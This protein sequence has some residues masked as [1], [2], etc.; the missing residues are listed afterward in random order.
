LQA[1]GQIYN[2]HGS[3]LRVQ[4]IVLL[5]EVL[6]EIATHAHKINNDVELRLKLQRLP[7]AAQMPDPP[8]LRLETDSYQAYI[9]LLQRLYSDKPDV[10]MG[11]QV[12]TRLVKVF[13][14]VLN[15]YLKTATEPSNQMQVEGIGTNPWRLPL[16]SSKRKEL[17]S[18]SP[19]VVAALRAITRRG[20]PSFEKYLSGFFPLLVSLISCEHVAVEVQLALSEVFSSWVGPV[21]FEHAC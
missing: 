17:N 9:A 3:Q 15:L 10:V 1:V 8:L 5:L 7:M 12:D 21:L 11:A 2:M 13:E 20:D 4:H 19:M 6:H 18:R 14:D 16:G